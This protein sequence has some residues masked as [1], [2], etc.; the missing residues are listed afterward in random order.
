MLPYCVHSQKRKRIINKWE[1]ESAAVQWKTMT[2]PTVREHHDASKTP[3]RIHAFTN[4]RT[5]K[6]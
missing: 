1:Q 3:F 4:A 2:V 6:E 5:V